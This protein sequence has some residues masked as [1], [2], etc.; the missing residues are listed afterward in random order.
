MATV[1]PAGDHAGRTTHND[2]PNATH[3]R[4]QNAPF[5]HPYQSLVR[6]EILGQPR[7]R[8]V[9]AQAG[10]P[11]RGCPGWQDGELDG[12]GVLSG[13][14]VPFSFWWP[15]KS[16]D[17]FAEAPWTTLSGPVGR[18]TA[19]AIIEG[20]IALGQCEPQRLGERVLDDGAG[21][22]VPVRP[23]E[24]QV[25]LE[26][27]ERMRAISGAMD[28]PLAP[29]VSHRDHMTSSTLQPKAGSRTESRALQTETFAAS[30]S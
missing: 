26:E 22:V 24:P 12:A 5:I 16:L 1:G 17:R 27:G 8:T 14:T 10:E 29:G 28:V 9:R 21:S 4:H 19:R 7:T 11:G 23:T 13:D 30:R 25:S 6:S 15:A 2:P 20:M 3:S 18:G